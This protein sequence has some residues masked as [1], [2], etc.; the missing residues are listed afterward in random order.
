MAITENTTFCPGT[1]NLPSGI[2][3]GADDVVLDCDGAVLNGSHSSRYDFGIN[4]TNV[5]NIV[6]KNCVITDYD[7]G[8]NLDYSNNNTITSNNIYSNSWHGIILSHSNSNFL[9]FNNVSN[10]DSGM[11]LDFSSNNIIVS[12]ILFLNNLGG[13][14]IV[15][16]S[17]NNTLTNNT[18]YSNDDYGI[19]LSSSHNT[20]ITYNNI[21]STDGN[22]IDLFSS[23]SDNTIK[24]NN[25]YASFN[26]NI[27]NKQSNNITA[28]YNYWGATN[29]TE[30]QNKIDD[31]YDDS[32]YGIVDYDPWYLDPTYTTDSD[33]DNDGYSNS[34]LG[35]S[36]CNDANASIHPEAAEICDNSIDDDC[37]GVI[38][39][40]CTL[41]TDTTPPIINITSPVN[42]TILIS[43]S[44]WLNATTNEDASCIYSLQSCI[45]GDNTGACGGAYSK[46]MSSNG[47]VSTT[48]VI[49]ERFKIEASG[50]NL[51]LYEHL[52][53]VNH[54]L[55]YGGLNALA[56]GSITNEKGTYSYKQY[57]TQSNNAL[58]KYY[59]DD[60]QLGD[61][62]FYLHFG[63]DQ[64][65]NGDEPDGTEG[66]HYKMSFPTAIKSDI[67]SNSDLDDLDNKKIT[68][69]GKEFTIINTEWA[70]NGST[71]KL[72]IDLMRGAILDTLQEGETKTYTINNTD[73]EVTLSLV[74]DTGTAYSKFI[75]NGETT[76]NLQ[77]TE[78]FQLSDGTL[79]GVKSILP[80]EAGDVTQDVV[81]FYLGAEK[82]TLYDAY[83][84]STAAGTLSVNGGAVSD[85]VVDITGSNSSGEVSIST[86]EIWW[87]P[88]SYY[89]LYVPVGGKLSDRLAAED[90]SEILSW[91]DID[92]EFVGVNLEKKDEIKIS[93]NGDNKYKLK[94]KNKDGDTIYEDV[95]FRL[96]NTNVVPGKDAEKKLR[97]YQGGNAS[98]NFV[99]DEY[100]FVVEQGKFSHLMQIKDF[101]TTN[102]ELKLKDI[103]SGMTS[104][105]TFANGGGAVDFYKNG[106]KYTLTVNAAENNA[107]L[108]TVTDGPPTG[109]GLDPN[110]AV[111]YTEHEGFL[112]IVNSTGGGLVDENNH[113]NVTFVLFE[114]EDGQEG[115]STL[116]DHLNV[117]IYADSNS[118]LNVRSITLSDRNASARSWESDTYKNT[119]YDRWGT[120]VYQDT[121]GNQNTITMEYPGEQATADVYFIS[122][123]TNTS[124]T[125]KFSL[126][127][128]DLNETNN[129]WYELY[130][131][132]TD[133]YNN[134]DTS[135]IKFFVNASDTDGDGNPD[136]DDI[137]DDNDGIN[138]TD[139]RLTGNTGS[140]ETGNLSSTLNITV[141]GTTNLSQVFND[142][143]N[144][145]FKDGNIT[146]VEFEFN[147]SNTLALQNIT[148]K[149]QESGATAGSI[150]VK[151]INL[152]TGQTKT[153]YV[154]KLQADA[155][156][157]VKDAEIA[158]VSEIQQACNGDNETRIVCPASGSPATKNGYT[159]T[160][161]GNRFKVE[162]L[163][164]S[165]VLQISCTDSDGDR[166]GDG[167]ANGNDCNDNDAGKTT[168]CSS[169]SSGGG[170]GGGGGGTFFYRTCEENWVCSSWSP[171]N[172][173]GIQTR[174]CDDIAN[175]GTIKNK[176]TITQK[177][178]Y[179][180][181]AS[182]EKEKEEPEEE[183]VTQTEA[184]ITQKR[185]LL[186]TTG[187]FIL[188]GFEKGS[189]KV[190][191]TIIIVIVTLGLT[192]YFF[193]ER[194]KGYFV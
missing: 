123:E 101:D 110:L 111:L 169:G 99:S 58:V 87:E 29:I 28:E 43:D 12:N 163:K 85:V 126:L 173:V 25:I 151:G 86:I 33:A 108:T 98:S 23:S 24:Y 50:D 82:V 70:A 30:I 77:E 152:P 14:V 35:G 160:N 60:D 184:T 22:G 154:D 46:N 89:S 114:D 41:P 186:A 13:I 68:M 138:D 107:T 179:I 194:R 178:N 32:D 161:L 49:G 66:Y 36:D 78:I 59:T 157:C 145:S 105:H 53:D 38:D 167:C 177:C 191:I 57:L 140:V 156:I 4:L 75:V 61:P 128:T 175:C 40:G 96:S 106:Y 150:L 144:V 139:D 48:T 142:T 83:A 174:T 187:G 132:C 34:S 73:Y 19:F 172:P 84:N 2:E 135:F 6:V 95:V 192:G 176:P 52:Y 79:I 27:D 37:D 71:G 141:N 131:N 91:A 165:G 143:L 153:V 136:F 116:I 76:D 56:D 112:A 148:I 171:C 42:G 69:L 185:G 10:D 16:S 155:V 18:I 94:M 8:I 121:S 117:T 31:Y 102:N 168:D 80:N 55:D 26:Y 21:S 190:G 158:S 120:Y 1:Y 115:M 45:Q 90:E 15:S 130:V 146:L 124:I 62:A 17:N 149:K 93:P 47:K 88:S 183:K 189:K 44:T 134:S 113:A 164:H 97:V 63:Q 170:T 65:R 81:E 72:T 159:C 125:N 3:I 9:T 74:T 193:I 11:W 118:R 133:A 64:N 180:A 182:E 181:P 104:T 109:L 166:Y 162:G 7:G 100:F 147:F 20:N 5:N 119:Y 51:N 92:I 103:G 122:G 67:D 137:D 129:K 127:I 54:T 39:E 188:K